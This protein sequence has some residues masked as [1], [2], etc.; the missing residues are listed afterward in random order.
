MVLLCQAVLVGGS[1]LLMGRYYVWLRDRSYAEWND[2]L[3]AEQRVQEGA[4]DTWMW[5]KYCTPTPTH[6]HPPA[7]PLNFFTLIVS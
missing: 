7:H 4:S 6:P 1:S 5:R 2:E 3:A